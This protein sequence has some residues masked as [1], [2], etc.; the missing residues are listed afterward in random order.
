MRL[1]LTGLHLSRPAESAG[2]SPGRQGGRVQ[3]AGAGGGSVRSSRARAAIA[4]MFFS[5]GAIFGTW[6]SRVP[7]IE[8]HVH[9]RTGP[10]GLALLGIAVGALLSRQV[11]GQLVV[12]MGSR[13]IVRIGI[14]LCCVM[15]PLPA[16]AANVTMLGIA[17]TG[18]GVALGLLDVAINANG[19]AVQDLMGRPVMSSFHGIYSVG[20]LTGSVAGGQAVAA[21]ASP[22]L[23]FFLVA[24]I[25]ACV[26]LLVSSWLL[27]P[28]GIVA[29]EPEARRG[30]ARLPPRYRVALFLLGIVG[31][32]SMVG[33]GAVG[34]WG[35]IYMHTD[36]GASFSFASSGFAAY[37]LAMAAGRLFGDRFVARWGGLRVITR[38]AALAGAGFAVALLIGKPAAAICGFT[39]LG[40]GLSS[41][42]PVTFSMAGRLGDEVAGPAITVVSSIAVM[43]S[44][45]GP[46]V[47][48]FVAEV[49]GLPSALGLVSI[50]AFAA[51]GLIWA[52]KPMR[53][54]VHAGRAEAAPVP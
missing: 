37:S 53:E 33:E 3:P 10:L 17:L 29:R 28:S 39:V 20:G 40:L 34:D 2:L 30:W 44:L 25:L 35:A 47:I 46:P 24:I 16:L 26:T 19:V 15:L 14:A 52:V 27:P 32:C 8:A 11:A 1:R 31:L 36:L 22:F 38:S 43:G 48:G 13:V 4:V 6:V 51:A 41:V 49:V 5:D 7:A 23:H 21:G 12:R 45:A 54:P 9:A 42:I 18:F 50:L